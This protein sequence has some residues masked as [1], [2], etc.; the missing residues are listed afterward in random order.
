MSN[1]HA[2]DGGGVQDNAREELRK[3]QANLQIIL[4]AQQ[5]VA[6]ITR[7]KYDALVDQGF[8]SAQALELCK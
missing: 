4:D 5:Y 7:A 2:I 1:V 8:T 6:T 3:L